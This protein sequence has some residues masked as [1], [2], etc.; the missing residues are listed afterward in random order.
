MP[1]DKDRMLTT[2]EEAL[3]RGEERFRPVYVGTQ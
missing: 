3:S 2:I 1:M